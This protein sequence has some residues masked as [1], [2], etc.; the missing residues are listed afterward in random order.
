[1]QPKNVENE[2]KSKEGAPVSKRATLMS[3]GAETEDANKRVSLK[4]KAKQK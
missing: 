4:E 1:M 2:E 3:M